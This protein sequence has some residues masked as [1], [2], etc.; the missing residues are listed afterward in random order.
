MLSVFK[1]VACLICLCIPAGMNKIEIG[2]HLKSTRIQKSTLPFNWSISSSTF[3]NSPKYEEFFCNY[4]MPNLPCLIKNVTTNWE[5]SRKWVKDDKINYDYI[6]DRYGEMEAPVAD[7]DNITYNSHCKSDMQV[8]SY[9]EYLREPSKSKLY[10]L[11]DWHLRKLMPEDKFYEIPEVFASDWLNEYAED[12]QEDDFMFVYIGP[13]NSW[14]VYKLYS[15][16]F[17]YK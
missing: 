11:K 3:S 16:Y 13:K 15:T 5:C 10:Y 12:K 4:L 9:M 7:C 14:Y 2:F 6:I 1:S 17:Y 8:S